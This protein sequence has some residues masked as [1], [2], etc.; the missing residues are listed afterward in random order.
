MSYVNCYTH[1]KLN[2]VVFQKNFYQ[3]LINLIIDIR[4]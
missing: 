3:A 1:F 2:S 4:Q